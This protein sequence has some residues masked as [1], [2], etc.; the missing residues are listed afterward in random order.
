MFFSWPF[1][2]LALLGFLHFVEKFD[3]VFLGCKFRFQCFRWLSGGLSYGGYASRV[4]VQQV[5]TF[6]QSVAFVA[7]TGEAQHRTRPGS[8]L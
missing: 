1:R 5:P 4:V 6:Y 3:S 8:F 7:N 2:V